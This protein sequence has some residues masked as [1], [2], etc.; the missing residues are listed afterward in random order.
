MK[1]VLRNFMS[2]LRRFK[3]A[4]VLN[5]LGLSVAF[6]VFMMIM[7]QVYYDYTFDHSH[8]NASH[9]YRLDLVY[10]GKAQAVISRPLTRLFAQSSPHIL[11]NVIMNPFEGEMFFS[12]EENGQKVS[13]KERAM[14]VSDGLMKVFHFDLLEGTEN[15]LDNPSSVLISESQKQ[16]MF[17]NE[18]A[19][20]KLLHRRDGDPWRVAGVYKDFPENSSLQNVMYGLIDAKEN[21]DNWGNWNYTFFLSFDDPQVVGDVIQNFK[22]TNDLKNTFGS[23][24]TW[25]NSQIELRLT[26]LPDLHFLKDTLFDTL[27]KASLQTLAVLLAIAFIILLIAGINFTNFSTALTPLRIKSINTQKVLGSSDRMLRMALLVEALG[28]S[29]FAYLLSLLM[30]KGVNRTELVGMVD[31]NMTFENYPFIIVG[32]AVIAVMVGLLAGVYPAFYITSFSPALV[33]K[34]SFGLSP[35]GRK[36]RNVLIGIQFVASFALIIGAIFLFLQNNYM[37]NSSLGYD[38]DVLIVSD[39]NDQIRNNKEA[40]CNTLK[41][42]AGI[43]DV[44]FANTILSS[45]DNCMKWGRDYKEKGINF[46]CVPVSPGFLQVL[47]IEVKEGRDFREDDM[48]LEHGVY[49]F[50]EKAKAEYEMI[51]NDKIDPHQIVGF[52]PDINLFSFR[53]EIEPM[54]F[55]V[56]GSGWYAS[57]LQY[58]YVKVK[59]GSDLKSAMNHVRETFAKFD[60]E[61]PF[62]IRFYDSILQKTY[63][64]EEKIG[65]LITLFS[66]VA[67]FISIVGVF[68]LVVFESEYRRKEIAVRKVLGSS[69][70][71]ILVMFNK[72]YFKILL[73]CFII[74]APVAW[75]AVHK[76]L[77]NFAYRTPMYWWVWPL[78]FILVSAITVLTVTY[79]NWHV[80]N[81]NPVNNV[82]SE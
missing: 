21:Y 18:P 3:T 71:E 20:G 41:G 39:V 78:A 69:T 70:C 37:Q 27:P 53:K 35:K 62:D 40:F 77:E 16:K 1:L 25:D 15:A 22:K 66:L 46:N 81:E 29:L 60:S 33:L 2:V 64:K 24:F 7:M 11:S 75:Y 14:G 67:I 55:L 79:Q 59:K 76:W 45:G 49:I 36:L 26:S 74:S 19:L 38:K 32:T 44:A 17:G 12:V 63:E 10:D 34:G 47:G 13:F 72:S 56:D 23:D 80:A 57:A 82:K 58:A 42:N 68:G 48:R 50:N 28:V 8:R 52:V 54:A 73:F 65:S 4:T 43:E 6:T 5:V 30:L 61:Y 31:V 51:L 9:I